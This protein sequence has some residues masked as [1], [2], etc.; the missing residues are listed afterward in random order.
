VTD[1]FSLFDG[2]LR[3]QAALAA[4]TLSQLNVPIVDA[5]ARQRDL[6]DNLAAAA[7]Q[8]AALSQQVETLARQHG[9]VA[10]SLR[11]ALEPYLRYVE[12]LGDIGAGGRPTGR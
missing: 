5:L 10:D 6:A 11:A 1:P 9:E 3:A 4:E 8:I 2:P 7:E 12:W